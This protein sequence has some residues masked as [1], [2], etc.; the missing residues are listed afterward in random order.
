MEVIIQ[1]VISTVRA[2]DGAAMLD[3]RTLGQ[4]VRAV[5]AAMEASAEHNKRRQA[6]TSTGTPTGEQET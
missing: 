6:D 4:I 2:I 3:A 1:D 5:M